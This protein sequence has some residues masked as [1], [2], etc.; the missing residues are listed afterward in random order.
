MRQL[1]L[2]PA[3]TTVTTVRELYRGQVARYRSCSENSYSSIDRPLTAHASRDGSQIAL[4]FNRLG[5]TDVAFEVALFDAASGVALGQTQ[6]DLPGISANELS[7]GWGHGPRLDCI[8]RRHT[9]P[10]P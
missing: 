1:V 10:R 8:E 7:T 9:S 5:C 3:G 2:N 6:L 4:A